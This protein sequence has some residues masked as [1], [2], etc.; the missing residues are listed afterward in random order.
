MARAEASVV[1][2]RPVDEVFA[3]VD[4][5]GNASQWQSYV[6]EVEQ[7]SEGPKG[8]G[9]TERGAMQFL[10]RR[11]EFAAEITEHEPNRRIKDKITAGP[12]LVEHS[13]TLEPVE[14][15]TRLTLVAEGE[16]GGFFR[17]A[18][19]IVARIFQRDVEA[20]LANL[21]DILEA[22]AEAGT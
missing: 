8:V 11:I 20:N 14:V 5:I 19:P 7:T 6:L 9:T 10:G 22:Q 1:I 12:M 18:E 21:K 15:G 16:T 3:Y 13:I 4:D 17:L 2:N